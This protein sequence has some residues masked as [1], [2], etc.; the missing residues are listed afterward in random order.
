MF[1]VHV[2]I[3]FIFWKKIS[4][5]TILWAFINIKQVSNTIKRIFYV[6]F[7]ILHSFIV[8]LIAEKY[9][10]WYGYIGYSHTCSM[11]LIHFKVFV[12]VVWCYIIILIHLHVIVNA[13]RYSFWVT[14]MVINFDVHSQHECHETE[15]SSFI[16]VMRSLFKLNNNT[17]KHIRVR[18]TLEGKIKTLTSRK[19]N[20]TWIMFV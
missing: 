8:H 15:V 3:N 7:N 17:T 4:N 6:L 18:I 12:D 19:R 2:W 13:F 16:Q 14:H 20:K 1:R 5:I 9:T 11:I 10:H